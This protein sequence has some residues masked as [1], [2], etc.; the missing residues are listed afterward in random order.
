MT[1]GNPFYLTNHDRTNVL[2]AVLQDLM[3]PSEFSPLSYREKGKC[4]Y[5]S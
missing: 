4:I 2:I 3:H 5:I 1:L